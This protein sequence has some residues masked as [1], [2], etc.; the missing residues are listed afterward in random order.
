MNAFNFMDHTYQKPIAVDEW[1]PQEEDI[2]FRTCKNALIL[3]V[4]QYF[5]VD[6][7]KLDRFVLSTKRCYNGEK[8]QQ[9]LPHYM[10]Y[11]EKFYD[12]DKELLVTLFKFKYIIDYQD[13]YSEEMFINDLRRYI[14]CDSLMIKAHM[15][16]EDNYCLDLDKK[17]YRNNR[18]P[19][20]QYSD[21][22][23][24][25]LMW[26]SLTIN[27]M[28][29]LITHYCY[30]NNVADVNNFLLRVYDIILQY[31]TATTY[32]DIY[33]KLCET[34]LSNVD[35][36]SRDNSGIWDLQ[37]IRGENVN[38]HSATSTNNIILNIIPK[39]VYNDNIIFLNYTSIRNSVGYQITEISFEYDFY[40]LSGSK[41]DADQS[42]EFDKWE[43]FLIRQ[44]EALY[45]QNK[46]NSQHSMKVIESLYGPFNPKEIEYYKEKLADEDGNIVNGFQKSLVGYLFYKFFGDPVSLYAINKDDYVKLIIAAKN[47]LLSNGMIILPYIIS[48]KVERLQF[49]KNVNK[50][51]LNRLTDD[52]LYIQIESRYDDEK[53]KK[54]IMS[55][56]ATILA[57]DFRI[58]DFY[59]E[60]IDGRLIA[61]IP[62]LLTKELR[63]FIT[64]I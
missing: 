16:N 59:D 44:N 45:L 36:N 12:T 52:D 56:I 62:D 28:I 20:L 10:N 39:Y 11:F 41:R 54:Q 25:I 27:M 53:V 35:K 29:P 48:G 19:C 40:A 64:M 43:S 21:K 4:S 46:V 9:H 23:G 61:D 42:S 55:I 13:N 37:D 14:L 26:M 31:V 1:I 6:N 58:I 32:V 5:N 2:I 15:M 60:T 30:M 3:P 18:N 49:R 17:N 34:T 33:S 8:M 50:R 7:D 57:S 38:L 63:E 47:I 22:H 51:E 24:K